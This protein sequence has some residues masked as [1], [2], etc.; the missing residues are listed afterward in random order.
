[1][2]LK[3]S[4]RHGHKEHPHTGI[5]SLLLQHHVPGLLSL[6]SPLSIRGAGAGPLCPTSPWVVG[7]IS[8]QNLAG[9][10]LWV[11]L[12]CQGSLLGKGIRKDQM[13]MLGCAGGS[14]LGLCCMLCPGRIRHCPCSP[15]PPGE[16]FVP[17]QAPSSSIDSNGAE[18]LPGLWAHLLFPPS[19]SLLKIPPSFIKPALSFLFPPPLQHYHLPPTTSTSLSQPATAGESQLAPIVLSLGPKLKFMTS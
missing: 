11:M 4:V 13:V 16:T 15:T 14:K 10:E 3:R 9:A 1:M 5:C 17:Q 2:L 18:H 12:L 7:T 6:R 19:P 8:Q